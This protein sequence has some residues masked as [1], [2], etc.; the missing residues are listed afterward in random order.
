MVFSGS[1][2]AAGRDAPTPTTPST[3]PT[4]SDLTAI[5]QIHNPRRESTGDLNNGE[6]HEP[7]GSVGLQ[8]RRLAHQCQC[9]CVYIAGDRSLLTDQVNRNACRGCKREEIK[10][11]AARR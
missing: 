9:R 8:P 2:A 1:C 3:T 5:L 10:R 7:E 4:K 11:E 6:P